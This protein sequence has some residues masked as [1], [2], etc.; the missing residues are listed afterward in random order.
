[1]HYRLGLCP[2]EI[3]ATVNVFY[4]LWFPARVPW[5][6]L[7]LALYTFG[8]ALFAPVATILCLDLFPDRRG[9]ASSLQGF[10]HVIVF[11]LI[12]GFVAGMVYRSAFK[13]ALGMA[14][15]LALNWIGWR[16]YLLVKQ[17]RAP[18]AV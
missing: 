13:H 12:S 11:A 17:R 15:L 2:D 14:L 10:A 9:L 16:T 8:F 18:V 6:V 7:P 1:M 5:A 4:N 3:A